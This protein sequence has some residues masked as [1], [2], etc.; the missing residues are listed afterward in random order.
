MTHIA[1]VHRTR[2]ARPASA[3][4][5]ASGTPA[6]AAARTAA[7]IATTFAVSGGGG[8]SVKER[9][10]TLVARFKPEAAKGVNARFQFKLSGPNGG[11]WYVEIKDGKCTC[12]QGTGPNPTVTLKADADDYKKIAEGEMNKTWAFL[13]GKLK[14]DGDKDALKQFDTYFK[15]P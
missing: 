3:A 9:F 15:K 12:K 10:A 2:K 1:P 6:A 13:R 11:D 14:I 4:G 5:A 7:S 8:P